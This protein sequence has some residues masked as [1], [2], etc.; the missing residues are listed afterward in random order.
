MNLVGPTLLAHGTPE[1]K[2]RWLPR[3]LDASEIWCQLFSEPGA[4]SDLTSLTTRATKVDGGFVVNGQKV[5]TSYAQFADW[6]WCLARTDPDAPKSKGISALVDRHARAGRRGAAAAPDHRRVGVQRGLLLRRVRPRRPARRPAARRLARRELDAHARTRRESPPARRP[7]AAPRRAV[8]ARARE[9]RARR[10]APR[11][12]A[13]AGV[14]RGPHLPAAQLALDLAHG[15]GR[16]ARARRQHQQAL[17]ERDEQAPARH[18]DGGRR[19]RAAAVAGRR[20]AI[21]A[22]APGSGR[23]STTRRARSGPAPTRS[24]A[25]SS[26]SARSACP[27]KRTEPRAPLAPYY[28]HAT[29]HLHPHRHRRS[30]RRSRRVRQQQQE[31]RRLGADSTSSTAQI[32]ID[33]SLHVP[34]DS[35]HRRRRR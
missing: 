34:H 24:S 16:G 21:P 3:I 4:G 18:R 28:R 27:A 1:Q 22:T 12:P 11:G 2:A 25:T 6:G 35:R 15:Q 14:R 10:S 33:S 32:T 9:R 31:S 7:L 8:A 20:R 19:A 26:A 17:V 29:T 23:G 30:R 13:R 5:W